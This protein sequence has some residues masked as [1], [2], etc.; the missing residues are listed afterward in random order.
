[1][2]V[3][4]NKQSNLNAYIAESIN[5]IRVTQSFTR[6]ER[7]TDIFNNLSIGYRSAWMRAV[8]FISLWDRALMLYQLL[9]HVS[10]TCSE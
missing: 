1:M 7:N 8:K 10:Y 4:S 3:Q 2:A 5:G 6:E 9:Q